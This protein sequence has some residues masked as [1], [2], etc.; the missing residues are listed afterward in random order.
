MLGVIIAYPAGCNVRKAGLIIIVSIIR[1]TGDHS[2][3]STRPNSFAIPGPSMPPKR[4]APPPAAA[5][6][7]PARSK[8]AKENNITDAQVHEITEAFNLFATRAPIE[9]AEHDHDEEDADEVLG[10]GRRRRKG[11]GKAKE[12]EAEEAL[13]REDVRRCL[14]ALNL[15]VS[16]RELP[17]LFETLDPTETGYITFGPFLAYAALLLNNRPDDGSD[18]EQEEA[19]DEE[20]EHAWQLFT[21]G[22]DG[23]ITMAHLKLVARELKEEVPDEVLKD[24]ILVANGDQGNNGVKKGVKRDEFVGVMRRAG[25]FG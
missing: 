21:H 10:T 8:L 12:V 13:R 24:M 9:Q 25:V 2:F 1:Q 15:S 3:A 22:H 7:K 5:A 6:P 17:E 11:K 16:S 19:Q 14:I 20:I 4:R 23:P 18:A